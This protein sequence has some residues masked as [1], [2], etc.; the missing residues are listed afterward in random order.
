M[1]T[2]DNLRVALIQDDLVWENPIQNRLNFEQIILSLIGKSE[3]V[4]L[5]ETFTTG[6]TIAIPQLAENMDGPTLGWLTELSKRTNIAIGGSLFIKEADEYFNRF[7]FV[8]PEGELSFY[9][10]RHL[11]SIG[12]ESNLLKSGA[13]R[14]V[15]S[16]LGWRIAPFICYDLRFPVWCRNKSDIDLMVF[17]A[18]WPE[19]RQEVWKILLRARAIENQVYVA[20]INRIGMDGNGISYTGDS[21]LVTAKGE[22]AEPVA[23]LDSRI[24]FYNLSKSDLHDFR[25][26]FP[27][28]KDAD[29]FLI[30]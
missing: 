18:N 29:Q 3:V 9:D 11:F 24:L 2:L 19:S 6:F 14:V 28:E 12:G 27:V 17:M 7:V 25:V 20:G 4:F 15:I 1:K 16:Y 26:K 10:K 23:N 30:T 13:K 22:V 21:Q 5:P 8:T